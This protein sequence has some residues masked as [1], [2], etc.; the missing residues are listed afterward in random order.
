MGLSDRFLNKKALTFLIFALILI[1][2]YLISTFN[3]IPS[4]IYGGDLYYHFG[5]F[6][7]YY[8]GGELLSSPVTK[9]GFIFYSLFP[10]FFAKIA[11]LTGVSS[12]MA[13]KFLPLIEILTSA[14][15]SF[16]LGKQLFKNN[17]FYQFLFV[18]SWV[19]IFHSFLFTHPRIFAGS[20]LLPLLVWSFLRLQR[21]GRILNQVFFG[22]IYG[23]TGLTHLFGFIVVSLFLV[24]F[25]LYRFWVVE[26]KVQF[27]KQAGKNLILPAVLTILIS[28]PLLGTIL[29]YYDLQTLNP[30][31]SYSTPKPD[32]YYFFKQIFHLFVNRGSLFNFLFIPLSILG[33]Y[34]FIFKN[35]RESK[36]RSVMFALL[37]SF[38]FGSF[39]YLVTQPLFNYYWVYWQFPFYLTYIISLILVFY[40]ILFLKK[41]ISRD[42]YRKLK[43][44]IFVAIL[45]SIPVNI[46]FSY[47]GFHNL[48]LGKN[49]G[50][51]KSQWITSAKKSEP[52]KHSRVSKWLKNNSKVTDVVLSNNEI[53]FAI[54]ALTGRK[55]VISRRTHFS[56]FMDL[57]ERAADAAVMF[58]GKDKQKIKGLLDKYDV[59]YFYYHPDWEETSNMDPILLPLR[60]RDYLDQNGVDFKEVQS[61]LDPAKAD[62]PKY[63]RLK[64]TPKN[65]FRKNPL[66]DFFVSE[67]ST[68]DGAVLYKRK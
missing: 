34:Y 52:V 21:D 42:N 23:L 46:L 8:F 3:N 20:T 5:M 16:L 1:Y 7:H 43:L 18:L 66:L 11:H 62:V 54:N 15:A 41:K 45:L 13:F 57:N 28:L 48:L 12:K 17:K 6:N 64:V 63:D 19:G 40:G 24:I 4:A 26:N 58:Y 14:L 39:H 9:E 65:N 44:V 35:N 67:L 30:V 51:Y 37:T 59:K 47:Q 33:I 50:G 32:I 55:I 56:P 29:F 60:Y 31:T 53:S 27:L 2:G 68:E 10:Y 22:V 38:F 25:Y 61:K 36:I 49:L